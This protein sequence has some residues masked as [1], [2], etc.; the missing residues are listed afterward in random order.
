M[1]R[2][3]R[4]TT[5]IS[6]DV[7][8]EAAKKAIGDDRDTELARRLAAYGL[9]PISTTTA[10][11]RWRKGTNQP[12]YAATIALLDLAGWLDDRA[13]RK[14][15]AAEQASKAVASQEAQAARLREGG[16]RQPPERQQE[17]G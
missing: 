16:R 9:D 17:S 7:L 4:V 5:H 11:A 10:V 15:T 3:S 8:V 13:I 14:V 1:P 12:E 2:Q 6:P